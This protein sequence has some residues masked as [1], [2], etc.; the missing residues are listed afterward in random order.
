MIM[1][2]LNRLLTLLIVLFISAQSFAQTPK[3]FSYQAVV[4]DSTGSIMA[5]QA[6]DL[7]LSIRNLTSAGTIVYQETHS[8]TTNQFG[9]VTLEVGGGTVQ[10]GVFDSIPWASGPKFL[11]VEI[12]LGSGYT[13]VGTQQLLSVP[14]AKFAD[15]AGKAT[16]PAGMVMAFAGDTLHIPDGW[17]LCNGKAISRTAFSDLF[18]VI[19]ISWGSGDNIN[20][21]N[22]PDMR[23]TFLRGV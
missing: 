4:R 22:L 21:F 15:N 17:L 20:T 8:A 23:G 3:K 9:L 11:E 5:S 2:K 14:Y 6:V 12:D 10:S 1:K 16:F 19:S 7:R 18:N 13:T